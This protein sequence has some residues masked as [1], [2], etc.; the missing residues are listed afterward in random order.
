MCYASGFLSELKFK[1]LIMGC[2]YGGVTFFECKDARELYVK[3]IS[4]P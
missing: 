2:F 4:I 1:N 3:V